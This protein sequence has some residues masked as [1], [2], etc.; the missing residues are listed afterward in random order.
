ML[1]DGARAGLLLLRRF[2]NTVNQLVDVDVDGVHLVGEPA[3]N[4]RFAIVKG[5]ARKT[6]DGE[7]TVKTADLLEKIKTQKDKGA[8]ISPELF[9][10][11]FGKD[12]VLEALGVDATEL[13]KQKKAAAEKKA[14]EEKAA[15]L[16]KSK[17]DEKALAYV[18]GLEKKIGDQGKVIDGI[19]KQREDEVKVDLEKRV[20]VLKERGFEPEG[21]NPTE[22]MIAAMEKASEKF[23]AHMKDI[24]VLEMKGSDDLPAGSAREAVAKSVRE[25]LGREPASAVEEAQTRSAI[26]RENPGLLQTVIREERAAAS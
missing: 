10:E 19:V 21:D 6:S 2:R 7:H 20:A 22:A 16:D 18:E 15:K 14:A 17:L 9:I 4:R 1:H 11:L 12:A 13:E 25:R 23:A 3:N 24:G 8:E 5:L 26:Y